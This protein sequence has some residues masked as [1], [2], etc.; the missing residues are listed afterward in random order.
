M[1]MRKNLGFWLDGI[2]KTLV[3]FIGIISNILAGYI[4]NKPKM[5]N[6]FNLCLVVLTVIDTIFLVVD[7]L[8]SFKRR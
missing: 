4:L 3:A 1:L 6:P 5:K 8:E 7:V 2:L